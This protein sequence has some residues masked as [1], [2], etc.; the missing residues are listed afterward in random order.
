MLER[1]VILRSGLKFDRPWW[2]AIKPVA[3]IVVAMVAAY[4]VN[5]TLL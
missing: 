1:H 2:Y 3:V 4:A 5:A